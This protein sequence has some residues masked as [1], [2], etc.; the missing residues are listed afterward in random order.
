MKY[1]LAILIKIKYLNFKTKYKFY[2]HKACN[3]YTCTSMYTKVSN[4]LST[5]KKLK[6]I[7]FLQKEIDG[8]RYI[9]IHC[10]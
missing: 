7:L 1:G 3:Y 8:Q 10:F 2:Y 5:N 6:N 4:N 9:S